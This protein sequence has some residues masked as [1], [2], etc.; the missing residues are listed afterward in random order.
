MA[1]WQPAPGETLLARDAIQFASGTAPSVSGMRWF[2]D[3]ERRDIQN[4][5]TAQAGWPDGPSY[6]LAPPPP[7]KSAARKAGR[8]GLGTLV[9]AVV[10]ALGVLLGDLGGTGPGG[11]KGPG[12][13]RDPENEVDDFPVLWGA[14]GTL[15]RTLP[16]QL[17]PARRPAEYHTHC[18]VTDRR[19]VIV[20]FPDLNPRKDEVLWEIDRQ[21]ITQVERMTYSEVRGE[22]KIRFTDGSWCR[23]APPGLRYGWTVL[24][25]L[26]HPTELLPPAEMTPRQRK[27]VESYA[28]SVIDRDPDEAPV[29][30]RRPSGRFLIEVRTTAP[31]TAEDGIEKRHQHMSKRGRQGAIRQGDI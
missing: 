2:R 24:R 7:P 22:A 28:A 8:F 6:T 29:V 31:V 10:I 12:R 11:S 19:V 17:D 27:Y 26:A 18:V 23:L 5:L 16:W 25:H 13:P 3:A 9:A 14:P 4:E 21:H 1:S 15:A 20:G 30:T